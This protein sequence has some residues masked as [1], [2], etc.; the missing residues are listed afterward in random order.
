MF[1]RFF[2]KRARPTDILIAQNIENIHHHNAMQSG[3]IQAAFSLAVLVLNE[4]P[5]AGQENVKAQL[6]K[7]LAEIS[8]MRSPFVEAKHEQAYRD[9]Y[10]LYLHAILAAKPGP[11]DLAAG[12]DQLFKET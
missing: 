11:E 6:R 5:D 8:N 10:S 12:I 9:T 3:S 7:L 2:Q 4:L 1:G